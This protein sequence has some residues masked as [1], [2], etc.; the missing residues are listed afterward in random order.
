MSRRLMIAA[1][2]KKWAEEREI[3]KKRLCFNLLAKFPPRKGR[4]KIKEESADE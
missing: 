2:K 1:Y 3:Q 4:K